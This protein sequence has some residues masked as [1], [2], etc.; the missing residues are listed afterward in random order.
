[1]TSLLD[2]LA[3]EKLQEY[4][5]GELAR[6][7][8]RAEKWLP[9]LAAITGVLTTAVVVKGAETFTGLNSTI[10]GCIIGSMI[11]GAVFVGAGIFFAYAA[12]HG[13]PF[14][15]DE[16]ATRANSQQVEGAYNAW[17]TAVKNQ[18]EKA[19]HNLSIAL[20]VTLLGTAC[21]G[22]AVVITWFAP[23]TTTITTTCLETGD[24]QVKLE[25]EFEVVAGRLVIES[26]G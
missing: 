21:L 6:V 23:S 15:D 10:Q 22:M 4:R 13:N 19:R 8:T 7:K 2:I 16:L 14:Q 5:S 20:V 24:G 26:C 18:I 3:L 25:G 11:L 1:M 17:N 9:G 12:A